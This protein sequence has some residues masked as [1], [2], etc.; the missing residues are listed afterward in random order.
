VEQ[1][2]AER[3]EEALLSK[4]IPEHLVNLEINGK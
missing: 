3:D 4:A 2:Q 1:L